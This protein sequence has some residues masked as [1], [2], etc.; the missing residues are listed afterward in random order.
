MFEELLHYNYQA[1][2]GYNREQLIEIM[3]DEYKI[4]RGEKE[5]RMAP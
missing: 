4:L 2:H 5:R 1:E 3:D